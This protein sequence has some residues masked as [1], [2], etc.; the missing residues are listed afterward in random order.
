MSKS[1]NSVDMDENPILQF[2]SW[3]DEVVRS[4]VPD[5]NALTL[6]TS[7]PSGYPSAR[8][9]LLK[10]I[11]EEGFIFYTNYNSRKALELLENPNAAMV[12]FWP[13]LSRQVRLE[14]IVK[15]LDEQSSEQ[16]FRSRPRGSQVSAWASPQSQVV[17]SRESLEQARLKTE[18][19]FKDQPILPKP[20]FWGGFIFK[21]KR[22]EFWQGRLN[23]F[24][25]RFRYEWDE[26]AQ[27][28]KIDRL[29]P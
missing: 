28:W 29:A 9:I 3:F 21:P 12:F 19:E 8:V 4:E 25:D 10:G 13:E 18:Q 20:A 24:H 22:F 17:T 16:Y 23:R 26:M 14:G 6:A 5:S 1:L 15:K 7:T 11:V 2:Q 27:V